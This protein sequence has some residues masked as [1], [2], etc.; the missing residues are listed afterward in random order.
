MDYAVERG[1]GGRGSVVC[2]ATGNDGESRIGFPSTHDHAIAVGACNDRGRRS[3][4][5]NYGTGLDVVVPSND[6]DPRRQGIT[7]T[8]VSFRGKG[9]SSAAYCDDFGGTSSAT[10]LVAGCAA[11]VLSA[12]A[13]LSWDGVRDVLT[14]TAEKIDRAN[15]RYTRG[16]SL[17]CGYGRVNAAAAVDAGLARPRIRGARKSAHR[18]ATKKQ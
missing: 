17:Q 16:Y 7:T 5:S 12:N 11:L 6:D 2:V 4:Y 10:P 14:S 15:A 1:R 8:D 13:S 18:P 9:Y 3:S